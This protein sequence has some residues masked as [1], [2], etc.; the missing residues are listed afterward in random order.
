MKALTLWQPWATLIA[1]GH[2]RLETRSW[3]PPKGFVGERM[4]IHAA[5]RNVCKQGGT[6]FCDTV[7]ECLGDEW[8]K[9]GVLPRGAVVAT[10]R[11]TDF[12]FLG[13][14]LFSSYD[15]VMDKME[16]MFKNDC[17]PYEEIFG[18]YTSL[19]FV[20]VLDE[21]EKFDTPVPAKGHQKVWNW[22]EPMA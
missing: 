21:L 18:D 11:I 12:V 17:G 7:T 2:K 22:I 20:W 4:A 16:K 8:D 3:R 6:Y 9:P 13:N 1:E 14:D 10:V 19:R 5:G 15:Q